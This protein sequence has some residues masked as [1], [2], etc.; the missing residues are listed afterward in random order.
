MRRLDRILSAFPECRRESAWVGA[1]WRVK[2]STVA[3]VFGGEDQLFR[4]VFQ[5]E[6]GEL[7]A[8]ENMGPPYF[9]AGWGANAVGILLDEATD[10]AELAELLTDSYCMQA[11]A[12]L[13]ARVL[14]P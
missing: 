2:S 11:P 3:H 5:A 6:P 13:A 14:R 8:F 4:I 7:P 9:R 10:W 12:D 1:R